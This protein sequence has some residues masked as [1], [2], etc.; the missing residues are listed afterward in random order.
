MHRSTET[1][2][3][4]VF[5]NNTIFLQRG[6][7]GELIDC[8]LQND[9]EEQRAKLRGMLTE[10]RELQRQG[11]QEQERYRSLKRAIEEVEAEMRVL[12]RQTK[13]MK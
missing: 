7:F 8:S 2:I 4:V 6:K 13:A 5:R 10:A 3:I 9:L 12:E 1:A 11:K